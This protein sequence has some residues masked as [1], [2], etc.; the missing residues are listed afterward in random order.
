MSSCNHHFWAYC[1][2]HSLVLEADGPS[3]S[4]P[5]TT[6]LG[7]FKHDRLCRFVV[8]EAQMKLLWAWSRLVIS[9]TGSWHD[10]S[11]FFA[12]NFCSATKGTSV[13]GGEGGKNKTTKTQFPIVH[14]AMRLTDNWHRGNELKVLLKLSDWGL[15]KA[16]CCQENV[17]DVGEKMRGEK[18]IKEEWGSQNVA[19]SCNLSSSSYRSI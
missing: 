1:L 5:K 14:P 12:P 7:N 13:K 19:D 16:E 6:P 3:G 4:H 18:C 15:V 9:V 2:C 11:I 10:E 17:S 8:V